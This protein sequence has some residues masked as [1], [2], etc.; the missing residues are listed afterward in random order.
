MRFVVIGAGGIGGWLIR[1]LA[2]MLEFTDAIEP[3]DKNLVVVDGD[4]FEPHN[5]ARQ[6]FEQL[7]PKPTVRCEE[8]AFRHPRVKFFPINKWVV[9]NAPKSSGNEEGGEDVQTVI[10]AK[11]LLQEGD[12]VICVV[13]NFACR[14]TVADAAKNF[15]KIDL[16]LAGN[17]EA[18]EG[19]Y[20]HYQRRDGQDIT[21][22]PLWKDELINP[23]DRN[24]GDLSCEERARLDGGT[25]IIWVNMAVAAMAGIKLCK[26]ILDAVRVT[27]TDEAFFDFDLVRS[28]GRTRDLP[29]EIVEIEDAP[30]GEMVS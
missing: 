16:I 18:Y 25:Q 11:D 12:V 23:T 8:M 9:E 29:E 20:Y 21:Q 2:P 19:S 15:D 6:D 28:L 10:A 14:A 3:G 26:I 24:P 1:G 27:D 4:A 17:N 30:V 5:A 22:N 7:G 13:D